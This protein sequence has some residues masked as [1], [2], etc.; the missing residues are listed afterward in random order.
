MEKRDLSLGEF[1]KAII[2]YA[3]V[4]VFSFILISTYINSEHREQ[5]FLI[6]LVFTNI[7]FAITLYYLDKSRFVNSKFLFRAYSLYLF[8]VKFRLVYLAILVFYVVYT[9]YIL[10]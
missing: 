8:L 10:I 4:L 5:F 9:I 3:T 6:Y 1:T 2:F 7:M